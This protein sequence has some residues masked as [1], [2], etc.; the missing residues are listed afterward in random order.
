MKRAEYA[1]VSLRDIPQVIIL[2]YGLDLLAIDGFVYLEITKGMYG[3]SQAGIITNDDFVLHL[4]KNGY[5]QSAHTQGLCTHQ[6]RPIS[7]CLVVDDFGINYAGKE[8]AQHI[9][10]VLQ[11]KYTVDT[12]WSGALY[13]GLHLKGD[14]VQRTVDISMSK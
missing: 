10:N 5:I 6:T 12:P 13:V 4:S 8:H 1:R 7:F 2:H 11:Q 9:I 3:L 14:Y